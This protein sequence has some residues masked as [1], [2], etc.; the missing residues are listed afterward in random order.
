VLCS[1]P[2]LEK[3]FHFHPDVKIY[4]VAIEPEI[5]ELGYLVPGLGDVGDRLYNV[6]TG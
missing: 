5:N 3:L 2:G 1:K 4:T 6:V